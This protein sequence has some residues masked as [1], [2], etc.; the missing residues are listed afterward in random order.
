MF[1]KERLAP[2]TS[3][4]F[5]K[6]VATIQKGGKNINCIVPFPYRHKYTLKKV[7]SV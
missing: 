3:S 4:S 5:L 1:L 2:R 7:S 6:E